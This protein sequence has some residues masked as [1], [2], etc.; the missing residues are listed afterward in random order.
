MPTE[1]PKSRD[2]ARGPHADTAAEGIKN[3]GSR[4]PPPAEGGGGG[5]QDDRPDTAGEGEGTERS[6]SDPE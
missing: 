3:N 6:E 5:S 4:Q 2:P 1:P